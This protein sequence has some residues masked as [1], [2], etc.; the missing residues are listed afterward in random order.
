MAEP[1][2]LVLMP[3]YQQHN[4][5]HTIERQIRKESPGMRR[6]GPKFRPDSFFQVSSSLTMSP[7]TQSDDEGEVALHSCPYI[8]HIVAYSRPNLSFQ[9]SIKHIQQRG[10]QPRRRD[11]I[12]RPRPGTVCL[13]SSSIPFTISVS[14]CGALLGWADTSE[15]VFLGQGTTFCA[16]VDG[17][18]SYASV[19]QH[20][21]SQTQT[22]HA[23]TRA[24]N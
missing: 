1:A 14:A 18:S 17:L 20:I 22:Q 16:R 4:A 3:N 7:V 2:P 12:L 23:G 9:A 21:F 11:E 19:K 5:R 8:K 15:A 24:R 10:P 6:Q 13:L